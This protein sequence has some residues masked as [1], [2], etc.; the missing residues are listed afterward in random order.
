M[1][2]EGNSASHAEHPSTG[3]GA[4]WLISV[5]P[6]ALFLACASMLIPV[7]S[8]EIFS[9]SYPWIPQLGI[10]LSFHVDGL[11]LLFALLVTGIG[12][13]VTLYAG[14]YLAGHHHLGRFYGYLFL[15]LLAMLGLV[16][17]DNVITLF[18]FWELTSIASYLLIG[19]YHTKDDSRASALQALLV[20]GSGGLALLAGLILLSIIGGS[21]ELSQLVQQHNAITNHTLYLPM[22]ILI[23][24]GAFTKSAQFPFHFWLPGAMAAPAP[25]SSYLHSATMVKAGVYLLARLSPILGGT[26]AWY[27]A[28]V[29]FGALTMFIGAYLAPRNNDM[30]RILAYSTVSA[31][32]TLVMLLGIGTSIAIKAAVV[33]L[34]VHSIYKASLFMVAGIVDHETGSRDID[35]ISGLRSAM[36]VTA[37]AAFLAAFSF[38]GMPPFFGFIGKELIYEAKLTAPDASTVLT[39]VAVTSNA[40]MVAAGL[41]T[42]RPF[43]G[44]ELKAPGHPHEAPLTM[45]VGPLLLAGMGLLVGMLPH[46][47]AEPLVAPAVSVIKGEPAKIKLALWHGIN[48]MLILS[49]ITVALGLGI[50]FARK[51]FCRAG[52]PFNILYRWGPEALYEFSLKMLTTLANSLNQLIQRGSLGT[53][54]LVI[55]ITTVGLAGAA[56]INTANISMRALLTLPDARPYEWVLALVILASAA[57]AVRTTSRLAA[58]VALGGVGFGMTLLYIIFSAPDLAN[59]QFAVDTLSIILFVL[60]LYRLPKYQSISTPATR[61][62]DAVVALTAGGFM[63]LL[64]LVIT[65]QPLQSRLSPYFIEN[66]VPLANGRNIVNVILV[67]YR[68]LD[69]LGEITVLAVAAVGVHALLKLR[70]TKARS[71]AAPIVESTPTGGNDAHDGDDTSKSPPHEEDA[72]ERSLHR[73]L[74]IAR[75]LKGDKPHEQ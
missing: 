17:A 64:T 49:I 71:P 37:I 75:T 44:K 38:A 28:L 13:L 36:P 27:F 6:L 42:I 51:L 14:G 1:A 24:V 4:S 72:D 31:L 20:T 35:H 50:F 21:Q 61:I 67:D 62:R 34:I 41:L 32:G 43:L 23:L 65:S 11:G 53:Y 30:K 47:V 40:L 60:V 22:L 52:Q 57:T 39:V 25:V 70:P 18:V 55:I 46:T 7:A 66:S 45:L 33:F 58:I 5:I 12:T 2:H 73:M 68:V 56:F 19:F 29:L 48:T 54:L 59:T 26:Q 9:F 69:T 3:N 63:T 8:G 10:N 15:F 74:D 16:L